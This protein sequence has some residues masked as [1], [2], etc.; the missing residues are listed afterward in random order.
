M[1]ETAK[2]GI[3]AHI[4]GLCAPVWVLTYMDV[5][6][7][8]RFPFIASVEVVEVQTDT[9]MKARTS[10]LSRQGCYVDTLNPLPKGTTLKLR[11]THQDQQV[12]AVGRVVHSQPNVGMGVVFAEIA[13]SIP[14]LDQWLAELGASDQDLH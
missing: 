14:T 1:L 13:S 10:D 8:P 7:S 9:H 12:D 4:F 11:F 6:K 2:C 5:R 3:K